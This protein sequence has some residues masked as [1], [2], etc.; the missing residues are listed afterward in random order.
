MLYFILLLQ[1]LNIK[2]ATWQILVS[3][4]ASMKQNQ[5]LFEGNSVEENKRKNT[6]EKKKHRLWH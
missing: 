1:Q 5:Q 6:K 3:N 2:Q 4:Q